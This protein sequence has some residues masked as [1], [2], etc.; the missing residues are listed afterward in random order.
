MIASI[1]V[2]CGTC[3]DMFALPLEEHRMDESK[4][5]RK[6][7]MVGQSANRGRVELARFPD[8]TWT[9]RADGPTVG[10]WGAS[11]QAACFRVFR[12]LAGL[13]EAARRNAKAVVVRSHNAPAV[14]WQ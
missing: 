2:P 14:K 10:V 12:M 3:I 13:D 9:V 8:G 7:V 11:E 4:D 6:V 1:P 5:V